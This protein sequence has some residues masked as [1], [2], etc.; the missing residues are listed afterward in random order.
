[1]TIEQNNLILKHMHLADKIAQGKK[2]KLFTVSY[3]ELQSAAYFGLVEAACKF[4]DKKAS[5]STF[6]TY[7]II[8]SIQDYLRSL[9]WGSRNF[10]LTRKEL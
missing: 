7:R 9:N 4:D 2:R 6:A 1:M 8:G 5:F 3:D 10:P